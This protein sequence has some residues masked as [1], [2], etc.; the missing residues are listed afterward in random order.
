[1]T[2][3]I[4]PS[5]Q[6]KIADKTAEILKAAVVPPAPKL[7]DA[8]IEKEAQKRAR[9]AQAL[10]AK[11][12]ADKAAADLNTKREELKS[13]IG[14]SFSYGEATGTIV[15]FEPD[16]MLGAKVGDAFLVNFGNPNR[17][18][19]IFCEEFLTG[20]NKEPAAVAAESKGQL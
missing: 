18:D 17:N 12:K 8:Q 6:Q 2:D 13:N 11:Q 16:K 15:A 3:Q 10:E 1:M 5:D 20:S 19:Y 4:E 7:T 14:K 9:V